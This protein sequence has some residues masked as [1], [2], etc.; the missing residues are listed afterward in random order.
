M[1][2]D[3]LQ[4]RT[5]GTLVA[6]QILGGIGLSAGV[7]VGALL[8]EDISGS[9]AYAGLGGTL[10]VLG[11]ALLAV[12]MAHIMDV[13]GRRPGLVFGY[14]CAFL[15]AIGLIWAA[16]SRNFPLLLVSSVLFGGATASNSQSGFAAADLAQPEHRGRDL[17]LVVWATTIGSVLGPN[18]IGPSE[19]VARQLGIPVL[20]GP[21]AFSLVALLAAIA[22]VQWRLRPDPLVESRRREAA[23]PAS[24]ATGPRLK[25]SVVRGLRSARSHP[26]VALGLTTAALGHAV[27]VSVMVMTPIHMAHGHASLR[28]IGLVISLHIVGM[29]AFSPLVGTAVDRLGGRQIG[30]LGAGI[31]MLASVLASGSQ[32][33]QSASLTLGLFLLGL[34]W[35]CT[36]VSGSTLITNA[37]TPAERPAVQGASSLLM[38]LAGGGGGALAGVIVQHWGYQQLGLVALAVAL[39]LAATLGLSLREALGSRG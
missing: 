14:G 10:Q 37:S 18:L 34:G 29:F 20:S 22:L 30:L 36:L 33:G 25:G 4:R 32:A 13:K 15:G 17:S 12:P 3:P 11:A 31:L 27:M 7:A 19:P 5:L 8:A 9:T 35:S 23:A 21:Y 28:V 1:T 6:S 38:G 26:D 24:E 39:A 2:R 16:V